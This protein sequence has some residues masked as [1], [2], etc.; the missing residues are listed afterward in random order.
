[1]KQDSFQDLN[2]VSKETTN[3]RNLKFALGTL[4]AV[5]SLMAGCAKSEQPLVEAPPPYQPPPTAQP[6]QVPTLPAKSDEV[7]EAVRR[8]FK[9]A[10]TMDAGRTPNFIV[11]DF[12]GDQSQD[13]AVILKSAPGKTSE[14][15]QE[16]PPWILRD[17]FAPNRLSSFRIVD[18]EVLLAVIHG[19]G[20]NGWRD[21]QATQTFLLK[22]A[23]GSE[24]ELQKGEDFLA[25]HEGKKVPRLQGDLISEVVHGKSGYLYYTGPTYSWY[26][27]KT[28]NGEPEQ[29]LV[30]PGIAPRIER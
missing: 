14:M 21:S 7:H 11:G 10:A 18:N 16:Y 1:M 3:L 29:H 9:D 6:P 30:H 5:C 8:V 2:S 24:I 15:N 22:N 26:D 23:V 19:Y 4:L 20:P 25:A 27:P 28:F 17:P 12:N 13:V